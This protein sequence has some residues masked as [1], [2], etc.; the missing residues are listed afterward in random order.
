MRDVRQNYGI[1]GADGCDYM[2]GE[3]VVM[4]KMRSILSLLLTVTM[5]LGLLAGCGEDIASSGYT[6]AETEQMQQP[7]EMPEVVFSLRQIYIDELP[8]GVA[9]DDALADAIAQAVCEQ[10]GGFAILVRVLNIVCPEY[11]GS[12]DL[13]VEYEAYPMGCERF[14]DRTRLMEGLQVVITRKNGAYMPGVARVQDEKRI[15]ALQAVCRVGNFEMPG[16]EESLYLNKENKVCLLYNGERLETEQYFKDTIDD[17]D[18]QILWQTAGDTIV[19]LA[20]ESQYY[21]EPFRIHVSRDGGKT[22]KETVPEL[23]PLGKNG[24]H[25]ELGF[26]AGRIQIMESG[27]VYIFTGTN[28]A[29]LNVLTVPADSNEAVLLFREQISGYETTA[30]VDAAMISAERGYVTLAH[31][32]YPAS[33][34]IYR[35]TDGGLTWV[36]CSVPMPEACTNSWDMRLSLPVAQNEWLEWTMVG[37]WESGTCTYASYDGGWTWEII[38]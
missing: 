9:P 33:N 24:Q 27:Q 7:D 2:K 5:L 36:R 26:S 19:L 38:E 10:I 8:T 32:K 6:E 16:E 15:E 31:P 3:Y 14:S 12:T 11:E 37:S 4:K 28:L 20:C 1:V 30:L 22:W 18:R 17:L 35:T 23:A 25:A 34:A 29:S 21:K 13:Y